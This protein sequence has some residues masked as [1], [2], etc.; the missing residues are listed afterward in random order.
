MQVPGFEAR[1]ADGAWVGVM[2]VVVQQ[3]DGLCDL[4]GDGATAVSLMSDG[5]GATWTGVR[6]PNP[7]QFEESSEFLSDGCR[8]KGYWTRETNPIWSL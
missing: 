3:G 1:T 2:A 4:E 6:C 5:I 7:Y 8:A